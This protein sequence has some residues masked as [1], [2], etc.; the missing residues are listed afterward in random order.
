VRHP[1][2]DRG[3]ADELR[4]FAAHRF[5]A[6]D[7]PLR[8]R[9]LLFR[10]LTS[11]NVVA[12]VGAGCSAT[13]GLPNW[14]ALVQKTLELAQEKEIAV[15]HLLA[16]FKDPDQ[17]LPPDMLMY[18]LDECAITIANRE[19]ELRHKGKARVTL[20][21]LVA[22]MLA[23][24]EETK[25]K[26]IKDGAYEE[27][28]QLPIRRFVTS[29]YDLV[30]EERIQNLKKGIAQSLSQVSPIDKD[31]RVAQS[32]TQ[33]LP[34]ELDKRATV[35]SNLAAI[36]TP[37]MGIGNPFLVFHCHGDREDVESM[38]VTEMDYRKWYLGTREDDDGARELHQ[39]LN[40]LWACS[41]VLFIGFGLRDNDLLR[42]LRL[43]LATQ[44]PEAPPRPLFA[45]LAVGPKVGT[46]VQQARQL[47]RRFGINILTFDVKENESPSEKLTGAIKDLHEEWS[48]WRYRLREK[49]TFRKPDID[50]RSEDDHSFYTINDQRNAQERGHDTTT[51]TIGSALVKLMKRR[52][53][54]IALVGPRGIGKS[55][56]AR[57]ALDMLKN[58][59]PIPIVPRIYWNSYY[60]RDF[61]SLLDYL[62]LIIKDK[63][64]PNRDLSRIDDLMKALSDRK[65]MGRVLLVLDRVER[66]MSRG[67]R[68]GEGR[69]VHPEFKYF[70][71]RL[72]E[73][74]NANIT[75][76]LIGRLWPTVLEDWA[77]DGLVEYDES[78]R[79]EDSDFEEKTVVRWRSPRDLLD[80]S[81]DE[82][83]R[84]IRAL[85][86]DN[87]FAL[88]VAYK[89]A[90]P[91]IQVTDL[92]GL[93][94]RL[95]A[96][97]LDKRVLRVIKEALYKPRKVGDKRQETG[98]DKYVRD[99]DLEMLLRK[100]S[101][102]TSPIRTEVLEVIGKTQ[103]V[104]DRAM[105]LAL[106][107][108]ISVPGG[109]YSLHPSV[110]AYFA[111]QSDSGDDAIAPLLL[112]SVGRH[113]P[114]V[115][116]MGKQAELAREL[117]K[118]IEKAG[119]DLVQPEQPSESGQLNNV[120]LPNESALSS[121]RTLARALLGML[122][123]RMEPQ[124]ASRWCKLDEY[125]RMV[126]DLGNLVKRL[127]AEQ[128]RRAAPGA[129][130][131]HAH[132]WIAGD[133]R[134]SD[135][136]ETKDSVLRA[137][138]L[139]WLYS[140]IGLTY[141]MEGNI[142]DALLFW[143]EAVEIAWVING[144]TGSGSCL[145]VA[146]CNLGAAYR[147][148]GKLDTAERYLREALS[149]SSRRLKRGS[150]FSN[151]KV[152]VIDPDLQGSIYLEL[153][154]VEFLR[155][156]YGAEPNDGGGEDREA[157]EARG[158][159]YYF[160][161]AAAQFDPDNIRSRSR[162]H[163]YR[164]EWHR[165]HNRI[166]DAERELRTSRGLAEQGNYPDLIE[167]CR[168]AQGHLY[169]ATPGR[170]KEAFA[171]FQR[172]A[173][174]MRKRGVH[175]LVADAML[176]SA[177]VANEMDDAE[178]ARRRAIE[179]LSLATEGFQGLRI[180]DS[181]VVL[182]VATIR[183][184]MRDLGRAYLAT[185]ADLARRQGYAVKKAEAEREHGRWGAAPTRSS[186]FSN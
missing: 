60:S 24:E 51:T 130:A 45:L 119:R 162:V 150:P 165:T 70:L 88:E 123:G 156:S 89:V 185:A 111:G 180:S 172:V 11:K 29:N 179:A 35:I 90:D 155:G 71:R 13:Y 28:L 73:E 92:P 1:S 20:Q 149:T 8:A 118:S 158:A 184:G 170:L 183:C 47:G 142:F 95:A 61:L 138:E 117:F 181:L 66:F 122:R 30:L 175:S 64:K 2:G 161:R 69:I 112:P 50:K 26:H 96:T 58:A 146:L 105:A 40:V 100:M 120:A 6:E 84:D 39:T 67:E 86:R 74:K 186:G 83:G 137:E 167:R 17:L 141:Y 93:R 14:Q 126:T 25:A 54:V 136:L 79:H 49:P 43:L 114:P 82:T 168:I 176:G 129:S 62:L 16:A 56:V 139:L 65:E 72:I 115:E 63:G 77:Q 113:I 41:P 147:Q 75:V 159:S 153:G 127:T 151:A 135:R 32:F 178:T 85:L 98:D 108:E 22:I 107:Y 68:T 171:E 78:Y 116:P 44:H 15:Q 132:F 10:A 46:D 166:A 143:Q 3:E 81:R 160:A 7:D 121:A 57:H 34:M 76:V 157:S 182:G 87:A 104:L 133:R 23:T 163:Y 131:D 9:A 140:A 19:D 154:I 94:Q 52:P 102:L 36:A 37:T 27:L 134:T 128:E 59:P 31:E 18:L 55:W 174:E 173:E 12:F 80:I 124:A 38:I 99:V 48:R 148:F 5:R 33:R 110:R 53:R 177:L 164:A 125:L 106:V 144:E 152:E 97:S 103:H 145:A 21:K 109:G 169:L 91:Q 4:D 42:P 101:L